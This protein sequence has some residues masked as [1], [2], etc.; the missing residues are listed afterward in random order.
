[1]IPKEYRLGCQQGFPSWCHSLFRTLPWS[2]PVQSDGEPHKNVRWV[3]LA[4]MG[5]PTPKF[6][7]P[8]RHLAGAKGADQPPPG[9]RRRSDSSGFA[10]AW[11]YALTTRTRLV[12]PSPFYLLSLL[13]RFYNFTVEVNFRFIKIYF[14]HS[15]KYLLF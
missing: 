14:V 8:N 12:L 15:I 6:S 1:M 2:R 9:Y 13:F 5:P 11:S 4:D 3:V 10:R 7:A